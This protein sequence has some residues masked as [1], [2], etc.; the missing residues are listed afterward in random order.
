MKCSDLHLFLDWPDLCQPRA[1]THVDDDNADE[2]RGLIR[3]VAEVLDKTA[4]YTLRRQ[5]TAVAVA[6]RL[7]RAT[8]YRQQRVAAAAAPTGDFTSV[9]ATLDVARLERSDCTGAYDACWVVGASGASDAGT[10]VC[11]DRWSQRGEPALRQHV[12]VQGTDS[13]DGKR[14]SC[15]DGLSKSDPEEPSP[16][17][18]PRVQ[19]R[20]AGRPV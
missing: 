2:P 16:R 1:L 4:R 8:V 14:G 19:S 20:P 15:D 18:V 10:A 12:S 7:N 5:R 11:S 9:L 3:T 6:I 13:A 17:T